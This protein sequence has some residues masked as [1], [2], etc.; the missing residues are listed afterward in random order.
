MTQ[1]D[2]R[3]STP[4]TNT[5][6]KRGAASLPWSEADAQTARDLFARK[7]PNSEFRRLLGR[8]KT[9]AKD[10]LIRMGNKFDRVDPPVS[11]P[12]RRMERC[13][14]TRLG[15][16]IV[17]GLAVQRSATRMQRSR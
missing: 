10:R 12:R 4:P 1:D 16:P 8:C 5:S 2:P 17:D 3:H 9:S 13:E 7:A 11:I 14:P 6:A 15:A